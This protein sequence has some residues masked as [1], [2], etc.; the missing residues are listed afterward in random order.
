[1][2]IPILCPTCGGAIGHIA[3]IFRKIRRDRAQAQLNKTG[4]LPQHAMVDGTLELDMTDVIVRLG[5]T[6]DCCR[7]HLATAMDI[8]DY[9]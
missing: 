8:R 1:M 9:Y 5:I 2:L 6:A 4:T 7:G 3:S